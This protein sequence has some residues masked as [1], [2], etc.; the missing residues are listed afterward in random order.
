MHYCIGLNVKLKRGAYGN[1]TLSKYPI[2]KHRN[3][4]LTWGVKKA[5]GCLVSHIETPGGEIVIVNY[6]LGLAGIERSWQVSKILNSSYLKHQKEKPIVILGDSN[7]R[8]HKIN[9]IFQEHGFSDTCRFSSVKSYPSYA[10]VWRLDKIFVNDRFTIH[11]HR[12]VRNKL[13]R[14]A[15]DHLP[16]MTRLILKK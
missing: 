15:S 1:A 8:R 11:E 3:M 16:V 13:T 7:D 5:R 4:D 2:L 12:V 9:E 14:I 6:H 10:P